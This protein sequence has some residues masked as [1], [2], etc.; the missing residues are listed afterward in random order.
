MKKNLTLVALFA[1]LIL[2]AG[3]ANREENAL[4]LEDIPSATSVESYYS[5]E[6]SESKEVM[7]ADVQE[8]EET[9]EGY[10]LYVAV[11]DDYFLVKRPKY[12][13]EYTIEVRKEELTD[14]TTLAEIVSIKPIDGERYEAVVEKN[15]EQYKVV[16]YKSYDLGWAIPVP[17]NELK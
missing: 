6:S 8:Y 9:P 13:G 1:L 7:I 4:N 2:T 10:N 11:N 16:R 14:I 15:G 12:D 5:S 3:C 17:E